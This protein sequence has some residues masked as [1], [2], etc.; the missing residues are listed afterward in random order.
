MAPGSMEPSAPLKRLPSPSNE[1]PPEA[2]PPEAHPPEAHPPEAHCVK[3][4][5]ASDAERVPI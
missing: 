1:K 5:H 4:R 2:H 3:P